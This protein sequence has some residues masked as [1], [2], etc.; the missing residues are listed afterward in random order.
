M[1]F[2]I[3]QI[4]MLKFIHK[5]LWQ[6]YLKSLKCC[7][8]R[9]CQLVASPNPSDCIL[10]EELAIP[11]PQFSSLTWAHIPFRVLCADVEAGNQILGTEHPP[12]CCPFL[13]PPKQWQEIKHLGQQH[14][15]ASQTPRACWWDSSVVLS[16]I[17]SNFFFFLITYIFSL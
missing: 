7:S 6:M 2:S 14:L 1:K 17:C 9:W 3:L 5:E 4:L 11:A 15:K 13:Q 12:F 16:W 10:Y 8:L